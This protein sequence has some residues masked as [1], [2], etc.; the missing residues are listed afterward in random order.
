MR[1]PIFEGK[2]VDFI[3]ELAKVNEREVSVEELME[4]SE[5]DGAEKEEKKAA[6]KKK[7]AKPRRK[8]AEKKPEEAAGED[9]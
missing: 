1:A 5:G 6:P 3:L 2:V 8:K 4:I 7:P 9:G